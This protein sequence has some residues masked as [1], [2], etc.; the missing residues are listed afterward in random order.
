[1]KEHD[2]FEQMVI[3]SYGDGVTRAEQCIG[4]MR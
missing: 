4:T 3:K 1:M 2:R